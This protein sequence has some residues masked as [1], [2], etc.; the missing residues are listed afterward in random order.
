[1][2][3]QFN[4]KNCKYNYKNFC[5]NINGEVEYGCEILDF[6]KKRDCFIPSEECAK[7]LMSFL[8]EDDRLI[9]RMDKSLEEEDLMMKLKTGKW[10]ERRRSS[11][12]IVK[13]NGE[14]IKY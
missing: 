2:E 14:V 3:K 4:C 5:R 6:T 13:P 12:I 10:P 1:M 9:Y 8:E 7:S 11:N